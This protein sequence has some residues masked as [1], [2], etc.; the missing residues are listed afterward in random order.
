MTKLVLLVIAK[1]NNSSSVSTPKI[2]INPA[3]AIQLKRKLVEQFCHRIWQR[4]CI[5]HFGK[6][7]GIRSHPVMISDHKCFQ[8]SEKRMVFGQLRIAVKLIFLP[9]ASSTI[10]SPFVISFSFPSPTTVT[11]LCLFWHNKKPS[12]IRLFLNFKRIHY[13]LGMRSLMKLDLKLFYPL[14]IIQSACL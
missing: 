5:I 1:F 14:L 12:D 3:A 2:Y 9:N 6:Q 13:P 7:I 10:C 8:H 11:V 4:G